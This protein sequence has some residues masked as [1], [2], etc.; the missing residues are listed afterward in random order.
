MQIETIPFGKMPD[1]R[2]VSIFRMTNETGAVTEITNYGARI[3]RIQVPDKDG[4]LTSV[5]KG[6]DTLEG[7]LS[8]TCYLGAVCG[9]YA[10]R[11]A[12]GV[13]IADGEEYLLTANNGENSLHGGPMGFH[14]QVWDAVI[15]G[16]SLVLTYL[17][18]D[19]EEGFPGNLKVEVVYAWSETNELSLEISANTDKATPVNI[20]NHAYFNLNGEGDVLN[21]NLRINAN[22]YV[23]ILPNA[24]PN[25]EIRLI[26]GTAFDFS[27]QKTIGKDIDHDEQQLLNGAGYDHCFVLNKEEFGDLVL[28][29]EASAPESGIALRIFTTLPGLQFYS[30]NFLSSEVPGLE[31]VLYEKRQA[32]CLEPEFFPDSPNQSGFPCCILR[33]EETFQQTII[34]QFY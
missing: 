19:N 13:F 28:A 27:T 20:T 24:I 29:A 1:G 16:E 10:N 12:K 14:A 34:F 17:S 2:E 21:H 25:G 22:R 15:E 7:Y 6:F 5:I 33:P 32:F 23:P 31:G 11:I 9:R 8:D 18:K 4:A 30:G 26:E 3:V